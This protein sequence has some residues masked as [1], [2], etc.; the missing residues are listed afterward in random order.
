[1]VIIHFSQ[2]QLLSNLYPGHRGG[3]C[4]ILH[5]DVAIAIKLIILI[6]AYPHYALYF[7][8]TLSLNVNKQALCINMLWNIA[9]YTL[10]F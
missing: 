5:N 1:M 10:A 7:F 2:M 9:S 4:G 6:Q 8:N 3:H